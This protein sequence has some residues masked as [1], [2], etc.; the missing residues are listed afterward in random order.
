MVRSCPNAA[1]DRRQDNDRTR[2]EAPRPVPTSTSRIWTRPP[3]D[4]NSGRLGEKDRARR[5]EGLGWILSSLGNEPR[6][7]A[8]AEEERKGARARCD[9]QARGV[10]EARRLHPGFHPGGAGP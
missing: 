1:P 3:T 5:W 9:A 2:R 6:W 4:P 8:S 7:R 10:E